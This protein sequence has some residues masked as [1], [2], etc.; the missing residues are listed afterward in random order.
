MQAIPLTSM[1]SLRVSL[2]SMNPNSAANSKVVDHDFDGIDL[3][4][5]LVQALNELFQLLRHHFGRASHVA[6][7][8][9]VSDEVWLVLPERRNVPTRPMYPTRIPTMLTPTESRSLAQESGTRLVRL[10]GFTGWD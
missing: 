3:I 7:A 8:G 2:A 1:K 5:L 4:S 10:I 6:R 9:G